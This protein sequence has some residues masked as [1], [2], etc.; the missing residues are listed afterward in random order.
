M[1]E[2]FFGVRF[3]R[4]GVILNI[5]RAYLIAYL[6]NFASSSISDGDRLA[7]RHMAAMTPMC[8]VMQHSRSTM[9]SSRRTP[10]TAMPTMAAEEST[11]RSATWITSIPVLKKERERER[12]RDR[13]ER[14]REN[15]FPGHRESVDCV[16][17]W[18][19][20]R[21]RE[22]ENGAKCAWGGGN[23]LVNCHSS[24]A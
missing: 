12:D 11:W 19:R 24:L 16:R 1:G 17:V 4:E 10:A 21:D 20:E 9:K 23:W 8:T 14:K 22:R 7:L 6:P 15:E 3:N 13:E 2:T 18:E 5:S